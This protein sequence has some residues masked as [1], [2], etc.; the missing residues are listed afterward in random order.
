MFN[1]EETWLKINKWA[2]NLFWCLSNFYLYHH[3][4][5]PKI[6]L[7]MNIFY[8]KVLYVGC[9]RMPGFTSARI[10]LDFKKFSINIPKCIVLQFWWKLNTRKIV[11]TCPFHFL[12]DYYGDFLDVMFPQFPNHFLPFSM[13][14]SHVSSSVSTISSGVST[15]APQCFPG[16]LF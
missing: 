4:Q 2:V 8:H 6:W 5:E 13:V 15:V 11:K 12:R 9:E 10:S 14:F 3:F 16:F 7:C 1:K